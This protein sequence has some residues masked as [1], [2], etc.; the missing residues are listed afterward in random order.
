MGADGHI[1]I[2][3]LEKVE[4]IL[5]KKYEIPSTY[6]TYI[7]DFLG[8]KVITDYTGDNLWTH[9]CPICG[10]DD[11]MACEHLNLIKPAFIAVWEVWT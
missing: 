2:Y 9:H 7:H 4:S 6:H 1:V 3:D 5:G 8:K 11:D 10:G